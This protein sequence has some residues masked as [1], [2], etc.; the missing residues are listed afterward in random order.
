MENLRLPNFGV[1]QSLRDNIIEVI[2]SAL[3]SGEMKPGELYSAPT[4]AEQFGVSATPV[5]E[6]MLDLVAEGHFEV[7]RNKGFR[8]RNLT[9]DELDGLAELRLLIEPPIMGFVGQAAQNDAVIADKI[10]DLRPLANSIVRYAADADLL[11][12]VE[13]DNEFHVAYLSLHGN[14]QAATI[15]HSL[16]TRSRLFG[17]EQ[18]SRTGVLQT[19]ADEHVQMVDLGIAGKAE[20]LRELTCVH[21]GH[22][23]QEWAGH[24]GK[25]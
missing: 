13:A 19:M 14:K 20:E 17:L 18:L 10:A 5:R 25:E 3:V 12:Y 8:V 7:V 6:A 23:R 11:S 2:R 9:A 22:V 16:R 21:I 1:R 15:V 4:L 24:A